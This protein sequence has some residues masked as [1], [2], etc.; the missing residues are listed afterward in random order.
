MDITTNVNNQSR[1]QHG[2]EC[3][4]PCIVV[5]NMCVSIKYH[6]IREHVAYAAVKLEYRNTKKIIAGIF[7]K[8]TNNGLELP[9]LES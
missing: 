4:V 2:K 9:S 3:T 7:T 1:D 8:G 5:Q 6:F